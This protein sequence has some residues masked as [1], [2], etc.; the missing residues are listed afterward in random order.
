M[1]ERA[2]TVTSVDSDTRTKWTVLTRVTLTLYGELASKAN[3]RKLVTIDDLTRFIKSDKARKWEDDALKQIPGDHRI[4]MEGPIRMTATIY[5]AS[6]RPDLDPSLLMDALEHAKV[7]KNDRQIV[8][9]HLYKKLDP[10]NPRV[11][12]LLEELKIPV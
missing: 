2:L 4:E 11:E 3:S 5:Y 10:G 1:T 7:Y 8:E 12:L 6:R 9:Q